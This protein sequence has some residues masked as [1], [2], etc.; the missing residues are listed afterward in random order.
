MVEYLN[1]VRFYFSGLVKC[2]FGSKLWRIGVTTQLLSMR[3][4]AQ[5]S[6]Q[7]IKVMDRTQGTQPEGQSQVGHF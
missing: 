4:V 1:F 5:D 7:V 3:Q 6:S 2:V